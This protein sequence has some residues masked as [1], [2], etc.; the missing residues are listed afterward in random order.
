[1]QIQMCVCGF[2][3]QGGVER[4]VIINFHCCVKEIDRFST[5]FMCDIDFAMDVI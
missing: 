3:I 2:L 4:S 1:M 5:R